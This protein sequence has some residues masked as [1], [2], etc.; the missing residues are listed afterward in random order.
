LARRN[1]EEF[2]LRRYVTVPASPL[3]A[4]ALS[5]GG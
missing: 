5:L 1:E 2:V 4:L 3:L